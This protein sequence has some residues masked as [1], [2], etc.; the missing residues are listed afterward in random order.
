MLEKGREIDE[1]LI[2]VQTDGHLQNVALDVREVKRGGPRRGGRLLCRG[3]VG[4]CSDI[5][6]A[7]KERV[8]KRLKREE[9]GRSKQTVKDGGCPPGL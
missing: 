3:Q 2:R 9:E 8:E 5:W 4:L 7:K 6:D 1:E